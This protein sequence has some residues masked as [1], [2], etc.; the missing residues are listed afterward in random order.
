MGN[1]EERETRSR[2]RGRD[3]VMN[4]ALRSWL[5]TE[6]VARKEEKIRKRHLLIPLLL[7]LR[8][9]CVRHRRPVPDQGQCLNWLVLGSVT[10]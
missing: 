8:A 1:F 4:G 6:Y 2:A 10:V 9:L 3:S 7:Q 5:L